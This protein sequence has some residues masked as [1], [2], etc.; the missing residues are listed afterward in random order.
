MDG[1]TRLREAGSADRSV[2][3][4]RA[5]FLP[6]DLRKGPSM[7]RFAFV[8]ALLALALLAPLAAQSPA[9]ATTA[10]ASYAL[11]MLLGGNIK[12]AGIEVS[13][14]DFLAGL[15]AVMSGQKTR[16]TEEEA[17]AAVQAAVDAATAKRAGASV[18]AGQAFLAAN[19]NKAGVKTTTSGLQYEVLT[20]GT[21]PVPAATATVTV[22]Y[23]GRL[24]DGTVFDSSYARGT[25]A[26]FRLNEVIRGWTEG[27]QLMPV[28]SKFR[29]YIP[30]DLAYGG[31]GA[32]N[33]IGPN[34]TLIF[35]VELIS[36]GK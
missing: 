12:A 31:R 10:D 21:G 32:G 19:K 28:G 33:L 1:S 29:F 34:A 15:K 24:I 3:P 5:I 16:F 11:G 14:D 2:A 4:V 20:L 8:L 18:A 25:P 7:K 9:A 6:I 27:L 17:Q 22:N 26:T 13:Y 36:I 30:S 23:E 35:D